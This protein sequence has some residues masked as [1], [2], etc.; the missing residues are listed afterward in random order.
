[1][2]KKAATTKKAAPAKKV[3]TAKKAAQAKKVA[4]A[5]T[6]GPHPKAQ[7]SPYCFD[8]AGDLDPIKTKGGKPEKR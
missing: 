7:K 2:S 4:S 8:G 1:M 6:A 3:P 5:E